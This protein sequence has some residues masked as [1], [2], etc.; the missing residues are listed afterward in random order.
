M[1]TWNNNKTFGRIIFIKKS[2][3]VSS[4]FAYHSSQQN[5]QEPRKPC[6][7]LS[8]GKGGGGGAHFQAIFF[9][10]CEGGSIITS[11]SWELSTKLYGVTPSELLKRLKPNGS[12]MHH[13]NIK[14]TLFC[15]P[16]I[17]AFGM[18]LR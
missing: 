17:A 16:Y 18:E 1:P 11:K 10:P 6:H 12:F 2:Y 15:P 4:V 5:D 9:R 3:T 7:V 13:F 14:N 8:N